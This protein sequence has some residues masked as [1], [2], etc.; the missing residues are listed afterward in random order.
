MPPRAAPRRP[1]DRHGP[2]GCPG[3]RDGKLR[4][5]ESL[6]RRYLQLREL[7][8][9]GAG[10]A[11]VF[12]FLFTTAAPRIDQM[13]RE[14]AA[15]QAMAGV[16]PEE[17]DLLVEE[18]VEE[19][20]AEGGVHVDEEYMADQSEEAHGQA[21]EDRVIDSQLPR[22][23]IQDPQPP[24]LPPEDVPVV[25]EE[26]L[27]MY[28]FVALAKLRELFQNFSIRCPHHGCDQPFSEPRV[29][30]IHQTWSLRFRCQH[31]HTYGWSSTEMELYHHIP[32]I[33]C[34]Q[35]HAALCAGLGYTQL[36]SICK[37]MG[38]AGIS[39]DHFFTFQ[40]G[41]DRRVGWIRATL[42]QWAL[43]K[44]EVQ[45]AVITRNLADLNGDPIGDLRYDSTRNG[46]NGTAVWIDAFDSR[47]VELVNM[48]R[49]EAGNNS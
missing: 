2:R 39:K 28:G 48:T 5:P 34:R 49:V 22:S 42:D 12:Q 43:K 30:G 18:A 40:R 21:V 37:E 27:P 8:G 35:Y 46:Y 11:A 16:I 4:I 9:P 33:T 36:D 32:D 6:I 7:L 47:V 38:L 17:G 45:N 13:A 20:R 19:G 15:R 14:A 31:G 10:P 1:G 3:V 24:D 41:R 29:R 44:D 25:V 23:P 26:D